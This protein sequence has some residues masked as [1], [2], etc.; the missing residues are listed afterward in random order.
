MD[1]KKAKPGADKVEL[2]FK[3]SKLGL[4]LHSYSAHSCAELFANLLSC[5]SLTELS[6]LVADLELT[7]LQSTVALAVDLNQVRLTSSSL[8]FGQISMYLKDTQLAELKEVACFFG[9]RSGQSS[10]QRSEES[11]EDENFVIY[12][13]DED[14]NDSI[15][16][17]K[18]QAGQSD[19]ELRGEVD[20]D[21]VEVKFQEVNV[22]GPL[23]EA[24]KI[25]QNGLEA[26]ALVQCLV[27]FDKL[28]DAHLEKADSKLASAKKVLLDICSMNFLVLKQWKGE[29]RAHLTLA[30]L[31]LQAVMMEVQLG[32]NSPENE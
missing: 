28:L 18:Q 6:H 10:C 20:V 32:P 31:R 8:S 22:L 11:S 9:A 19:K 12:E 21:T 2:S 3:L 23:D 5:K 7:Q 26:F 24:V 17:G 29:K 15:S 1:K 14:S 13:D 30:Q 4:E 16:K 25:Y 27:C